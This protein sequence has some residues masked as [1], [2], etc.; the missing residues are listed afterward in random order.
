[1]LGALTS[2][3]EMRAMAGDPQD[4]DRSPDAVRVPFLFVPHGEAPPPGWLAAHPDAIKVPATFVPHGPAGRM[5]DD[6]PW[7]STAKAQPW[8]A[9]RFGHPLRPFSDDGPDERAPGEGL[10]D[11]TPG[12]PDL[13]AAVAA[14]LKVDAAIRAATGGA[15]AGFPSG[16]VAL[17]DDTTQAPPEQSGSSQPAMPPESRDV[18]LREDSAAPGAKMGMF[19]VETLPADAVQ[20]TAPD[21]TKFYAPPSANFSAAQ[22][23][24]SKIANMPFTERVAAIRAA[25]GRGG[26]FDFQRS[27]DTFYPAYTDASNYAVGVLMQ[28][29]GYA[30]WE[31]DLIAGGYAAIGSS[32]GWTTRQTEW[33]DRGWSAANDGRL[34]SPPR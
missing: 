17:V 26:I 6:D 15:P 13:D 27:G 18:G 33:W 10:P 14:Y 34:P 24:G 21:G 23:Y 8:P 1:M 19:R 29:A 20:Y 12:I 31:T 7:P 16:T 3:G 22:A 28:G 30:E 9:N 32:Q 25:I 4:D 2:K 5:R 11:A